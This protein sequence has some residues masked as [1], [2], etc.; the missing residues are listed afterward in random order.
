MNSST[1]N[2]AGCLELGETEGLRAVTFPSTARR[3]R[4]P[5]IRWLLG[6]VATHQDCV[7]CGGE[8]SRD[9]AMECAG[10]TD[11]VR[12]EFADVEFTGA[13]TP[14]DE[15]LNAKRHDCSEETME[16][17]AHIIG[18][19]FLRCLDHR[20]TYTGWWTGRGIG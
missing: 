20:Q 13:L 14:M 15:V 2:V 8:L 10:V 4:V 9:H 18:L 17:L 11:I 7:R 12:E 16:K 6:T 5:I 3:N 1:S 19:I